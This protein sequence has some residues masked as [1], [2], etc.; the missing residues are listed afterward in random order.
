MA[1]LHQL[2]HRFST[3]KKDKGGYSRWAKPEE[4]KKQLVEVDPKAYK[5]NGAGIAVINNGKR[6]W[7]DN[8]EAHNIIVGATGSG[9][10]QIVVFPLVQTLAKHDESM[11]ITDPKGEIYETTANMLRERGY[12]I[13]ILNFR[14][15]QNGNA[16]NPMKMLLSY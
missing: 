16:W 12:N 10:T 4:I 15:P 11:I 9:K 5:S 8:G 2:N 3:R 13:V 7:V 1:F 6:L 14:N